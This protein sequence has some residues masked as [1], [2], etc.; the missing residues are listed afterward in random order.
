[1]KTSTSILKE[2]ISAAIANMVK[3]RTPNK[4][5]RVHLKTALA[6]HHEEIRDALKNGYDWDMIATDISV[7]IKRKIS[8]STLKRIVKNR[9]KKPAP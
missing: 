9:D 4:P 6:P 7:A 1:M 2:T 5:K 8:P 3:T